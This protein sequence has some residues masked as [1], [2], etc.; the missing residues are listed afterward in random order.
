MWR[1]YS[2][3]CRIQFV[4]LPSCIPN[5]VA[6][7]YSNWFADRPLEYFS[8]DNV[9]NMTMSIRATI[10]VKSLC[11]LLWKQHRYQKSSFFSMCSLQFSFSTILSHFYQSAIASFPWRDVQSVARFSCGPSFVQKEIY[12]IIFVGRSNLHQPKNSKNKRNISAINC[13]FCGLFDEEA[14]QCD[15]FFRGE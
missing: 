1:F 7:T 13:R 3:F 14:G 9:Y 10:L 5:S 4:H 2:R 15:N 8:Q 12:L 11:K 6:E